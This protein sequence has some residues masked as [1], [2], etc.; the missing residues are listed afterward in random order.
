MSATGFGTLSGGVLPSALPV[1]NLTKPLPGRVL[2]APMAGYTD[3]PYRELMKEFKIPVLFTEMIDSHA[4]IYRNDKTIRM[5]G[6][7]DPDLITQIAAGTP[8]LA[9]GAV[10]VL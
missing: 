7:R 2:S 9:D 8:E 6:K 10:D 3:P 5:L 4:L 1:E